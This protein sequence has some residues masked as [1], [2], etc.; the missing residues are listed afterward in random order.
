MKEG[1]R[2]GGKITWTEAAEQAFLSL[3]AY[4]HT[5]PTLT[6]PNPG[7]R[8]YLYLAVTTDALSAVLLRDDNGV[9]RPVYYVNKLLQGAEQ[10][11]PPIE[12][13][14]LALVHASRRLKHYFQAHPVT[15]L[16]NQPLHQILFKP[17]A[18]GRLVKWAV[19]LGEHDITF[20]PRQAVKG[21][22]LA[23]FL[24]SMPCVQDKDLALSASTHAF[25][26]NKA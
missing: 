13:L 9:Q 24:V 11:Y 5:L 3:K 22:V 12:K 20:A 8:L 17:E 6:T 1:I 21:Q 19:E 14:V 16:T 26:K 10:R 23:D 18:S 4:L 2:D 15:V 7:E 25:K